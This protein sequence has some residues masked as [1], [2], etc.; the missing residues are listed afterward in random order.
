MPPF[1][2]LSFNLS[3]QLHLHRYK[4]RMVARYEDAVTKALAMLRDHG[5]AGTC[6]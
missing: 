2:R 4:V 1:F 3:R 6:R 5:V